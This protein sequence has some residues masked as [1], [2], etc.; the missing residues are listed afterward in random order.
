MQIPLDQFEQIIDEKIIERGLSYFK[1][2]RVHE[3]EE[4]SPNVFETIVE[5]SEDYNVQLTVENNVV[6]K[7][8]CDCPYDMGPVCKHVAAVIFALQE[9]NLELTKPKPKKKAASKTPKKKS[10]TSQI[11]E[12][13]NKASKEELV[14]LIQKEAKRNANFQ[15]QILIAL[16]HYNENLSQEYYELHIK[17][18]LDA[19]RGRYGFLDY[20][21][22][23][24]AGLAVS[25]MLDTAWKHVHNRNFQTAL[26]ICFAVLEKMGVAVNAADDSNGNIGGC[27]CQAYET[28]CDIANNCEDQAIKRQIFDFCIRKYESKV[29]D[30]WDLHLDL[31]SLAADLVSNDDDDFKRLIVLTEEAQG[32]EYFKK[33]CQAVKYRLLKKIKGEAVAEAF[34]QENIQNDRFR[35][36]AIEQALKSSNYDIAIKLAKDGVKQDMKTKPGLAMEWYDWLL[37]TAQAQNDVPKIIEYA[38]YLLIDNF[39]NEQDYYQI[40]KQHVK[41]EEWNAF[42]KNII[43]DIKSQKRWINYNLIAKIYIQEKW[44]SQ[45]WEIVKNDGNL[46]TIEQ[47][48][49]YLSKD[50]AKELAELY[51]AKILLFLN[52]NMGRSHYVNACRYIRRIIKLGEQSKANEVIAALKAKYKNR[53]ALIQELNK[54]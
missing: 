48:E 26:N 17:T 29:F 22:S 9:K 11:N 2:G 41:Q 28:L 43:Q 52:R 49:S 32:S 6:T 30:G 45:L 16:E 19:L 53:P 54:V 47:Y 34:L 51:A 23:I 46:S 40:L 12:M 27:I 18:I 31:F 24:A 36:I 10:I 20:H 4:V 39:R 33:E 44:W 42:V 50:Y 37:K 14:Q 35:R 21:S 25:H 5:G 15:N 8:R 7:Y 3:L 13:L 38:R 1:K